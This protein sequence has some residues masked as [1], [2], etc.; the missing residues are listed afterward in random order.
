MNPPLRPIVAFIPSSP[1]S[2]ALATL[3]LFPLFL[4][5]IRM[6]S[7]FLFTVIYFLTTAL[8][9][10]SG[11]CGFRSPAIPEVVERVL[12]SR[13]VSLMS[14]TDIS[15]FTP[16][17]QFARAAYCQQSQGKN[18]SCGG[19]LSLSF[20]IPS[21]SPFDCDRLGGLTS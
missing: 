9:F 3:R 7:S 2:S 17:T 8:I 20:T 21:S 10:E 6:L 4:H 14:A 15:S 5:S 12:E 13:A 16:Y 19:E 18:W 11:R 1:C